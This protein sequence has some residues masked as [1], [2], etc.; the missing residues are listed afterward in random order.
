VYGLVEESTTA[1]HP[2]IVVPFDVNPTVPVGDD[3]PVTVAVKVTDCPKVEGFRLEPTLV[4]VAVLLFTTWPPLRVPLLL[5]LLLSPEYV[6]TIVNVPALAND[7]LHCAEPDASVT[8]EQPVIVVP[9]E[10]N[11]TVPV[12]DDPPLTVA[13]N[14]TD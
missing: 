14:V 8:A 12:G 7:V 6:A 4:V 5:E 11:P 1:E 10:V 2:L 3:P 9:F 13:V